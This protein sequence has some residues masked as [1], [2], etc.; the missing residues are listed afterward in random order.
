MAESQSVSAAAS[1]FA[2]LSIFSSPD[3]TSIPIRRSRPPRRRSSTSPAVADTLWEQG[4]G[5]K[6]RQHRFQLPADPD[7]GGK[8]QPEGQPDRPADG[9]AAAKAP[10]GVDRKGRQRRDLDRHR[11]RRP[12]EPYSGNGGKL[13]AAEPDPPAPA[14]RPV[15]APQAPEGRRQDGAAQRRGGERLHDRIGIKQG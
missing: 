2:A 12:V 9:P 11:H 8:K 3:A 6:Q 13:P 4:H 14:R 15:A 10:D 7:R 5:G 1:D